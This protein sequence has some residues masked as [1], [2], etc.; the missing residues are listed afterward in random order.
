MHI[1]M[2][3]IFFNLGRG[4]EDGSTAKSMDSLCRGHRFHSAPIS[5][6]SQP[7]VT[8]GPRTPIPSSDLRRH[9]GLTMETKVALV[10]VLILNF[11]SWAPAMFGF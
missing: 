3:V 1:E 6:D 11:H 9:Q 2:N 8:P 10:Y 5:E 4:E 7:P